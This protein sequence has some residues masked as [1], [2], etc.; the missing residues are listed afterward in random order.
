MEEHVNSNKQFRIYDA[1]GKFNRY[2]IDEVIANNFNQ[3]TGWQCSA[4]VRGIYIDYDGNVWIGNCASSNRDKT[5][6]YDKSWQEFIDNQWAISRFNEFGPEPHIEWKEKNIVYPEGMIQGNP[7]VKCKA[8]AQAWAFADA[9]FVKKF[10]EHE[11]KFFSTLETKL[12]KK[13]NETGSGFQWQATPNDIGKVWGLLGNIYNEWITATEWVTCKIDACGCGA[14]VILSKSKDVDSK[15]L[16]Q[17]TN[18][19]YEGQFNSRNLQSNE[20]HTHVA[21]EM[22]FPIDYQI[23]WDITR[24]CNYSCSYCWPGVHNNSNPHHDWDVIQSTLH[25]A[26]NEW[27]PGKTIRWNFG[28]G[29]PTLH[30]KFLDIMQILKD[31][32]QWTMV[33]TNGSLKP[34]FWDKAKKLLNTV[35]FSCHFETLDEDQFINN[36]KIVLD[37]HD[38]CNDDLWCEIKLMSPPGVVD[39]AVVLKAKINSL[40]TFNRLGLNG[41]KKGAISIVPIRGITDS[42]RVVVN[43]SPAELLILQNQ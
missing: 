21:V 37:W 24:R 2:S 32:N 9:I 22:D 43:Y 35:N 20:I 13:F 25:K 39:R 33:T 27:A 1:T 41:R 12:R 10:Q 26:I 36:I 4:G 34:A 14:D 11:D 16:L 7:E 38:E 5:S 15:K 6:L 23:L 18:N 8:S 19:K 30:P 3:W 42:N 17:V 28:G 31:N 40:E 29:E